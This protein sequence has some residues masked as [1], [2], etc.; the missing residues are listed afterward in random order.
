MK[1][2]GFFLTY[3]VVPTVISYYYIY[4]TIKEDNPSIAKFLYYKGIFC[5][6]SVIVAILQI[7][8]DESVVGRYV[9]GLTLA[10]GIMDAI[11]SIVDGIKTGKNK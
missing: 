6:Y 8:K 5:S 10:L 4:G 1:Y 3:L 11:S 2:I 7:F 9:I